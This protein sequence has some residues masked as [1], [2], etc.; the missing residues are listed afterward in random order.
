MFVIR[1]SPT[2]GRG[3]FAARTIRKGTRIVEYRGARIS[4]QDADERPP[5]DSTNPYHTFLLD[6][7]DGTVIDASQRGNVSRWINHSCDPNCELIEYEGRVFIHA[8]RTIHAC[9]ELRYDYQLQYEGP[10]TART[11]R[12]FA[13]HCGARCCRGTM[14]SRKSAP[15][16]TPGAKD[17]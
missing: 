2:H 10:L 1:P 12:A 14:L 4:S 17:R 11:Q 9:E 13:C 5:T 8:R 6:L 3:A 16:V 7:G 15:R